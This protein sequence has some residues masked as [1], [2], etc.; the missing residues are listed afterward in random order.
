MQQVLDSDIVAHD[1]A[2]DAVDLGL[3]FANLFL[4]F[5]ELVLQRLDDLLSDLLLLFEL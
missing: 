3:L 5:G 2:L 1:G 4:Q